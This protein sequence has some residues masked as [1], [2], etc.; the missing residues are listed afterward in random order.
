MQVKLTHLNIV[1]SRAET[2]KDPKLLLKKLKNEKE[3]INELVSQGEVDKAEEMKKNIAWQK[4]LDKV[5]GKKVFTKYETDLLKIKI[6]LEI[7]FH[8]SFICFIVS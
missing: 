8:H 5:A 7:I 2:I 3:Q 6:E 4:A 1:L